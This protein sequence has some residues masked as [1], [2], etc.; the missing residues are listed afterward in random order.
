MNPMRHE[1]DASPDDAKCTYCARPMPRLS[2]AESNP[3][4]DVCFDELKA[5]LREKEK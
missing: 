1:P 3:V 5:R 2:P 4:C